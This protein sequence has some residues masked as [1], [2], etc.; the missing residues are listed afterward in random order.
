MPRVLSPPGVDLPVIPEL[1]IAAE[2][3]GLGL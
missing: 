3:L 2:A 1:D